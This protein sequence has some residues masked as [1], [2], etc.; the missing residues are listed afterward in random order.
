MWTAPRETPVAPSPN[1]EYCSLAIQN[2]LAVFGEAPREEGGGGKEGGREKKKKVPLTPIRNC[3]GYGVPRPVLTSICL[4][5]LY[6]ALSLFDSALLLEPEPAQG[7]CSLVTVS[8][9]AASM[10]LR[11]FSSWGCRSPPSPNVGFSELPLFVAVSAMCVASVSGSA[12]HVS[13]LSSFPA[14]SLR[15]TSVALAR[16]PLLCWRRTRQLTPSPW[17]SSTGDLTT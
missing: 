9:L 14:Y 13:P 16:S 17:S 15:D 10:S 11:S 6:L 1:E 3:G 5:S 7:P 4:C 2:R 12:H 8:G